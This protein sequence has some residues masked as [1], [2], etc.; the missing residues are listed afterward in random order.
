MSL[1]ILGIVIAGTIFA[2][3]ASIRIVR[4]NQNLV[5]ETL[6]KF[7]REAEQGI[8][9]LIPLV[10]RGIIV[11]IT[12]QM[13]DVQPQMVITKDNLNAEVDA[14][15]YYQV[16]DPKASLYNVTE[17]KTQLVSLARTTL[18]AVI[19]KMSLT[20]ANENRDDINAKVAEILGKETENYGVEVLRVEIQKI[21]PPQDVQEAMNMVVKAEKK[22]I[23]ASDI[24]NALEIEADGTRRAAIKVA[25]GE[26]QA[27][28]LRAN[29]QAESIRVVNEAAERYFK[30]N[31]LLLKKLEVTESSLKNNTKYIFSEK[32]LNPVLVFGNEGNEGN[33]GIVPVPKTKV[34]K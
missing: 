31:A 27:V 9:F 3:A 14:I 24:A 5:I 17:H 28:K 20:E 12:E 4:P 16:S 18:R 1:I 7:S 34:T 23:A 8:H 11:N 33:E 2:I 30:G 13:T 6:G 22:K 15:V 21:E 26:A 10:Q 29:A 32:G 25:E 19:G